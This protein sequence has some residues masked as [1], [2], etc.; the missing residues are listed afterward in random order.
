MG[1]KP[2]D[3]YN[4]LPL[5]AYWLIYN[6]WFRDQNLIDPVPIVKD[7]TP[8]IVEPSAGFNWTAPAT[9]GKRHDYFTSCLPWP[10]KGEA[11]EVPLGTKAYV[12][13]ESSAGTDVTAFYYNA[14]GRSQLV[15][16][17]SG[18]L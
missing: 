11:V 3:S 5:R 14:S 16:C 10:Q 15:N 8:Y 2:I 12:G 6:E 9:R 17:C 7:D 18:C 1:G 13:V 4:I